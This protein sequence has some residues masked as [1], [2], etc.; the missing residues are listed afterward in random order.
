MSS[1]VFP[2]LREYSSEVTLHLFTKQVSVQLIRSQGGHDNGY[3]STLSSLENEGLL[4][5]IVLLRGYKTLAAEFQHFDLPHLD[6][7]GV[8]MTKRL[9]TS[10]SHRRSAPSTGVASHDHEKQKTNSKNFP[11]GTQSPAI[12]AGTQFGRHLDPS[13]V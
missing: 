7:E 8:F 6:I 4:Q 5:K 10:H 11:S 2:K 9:P 13:L 3:T 12:F 1:P